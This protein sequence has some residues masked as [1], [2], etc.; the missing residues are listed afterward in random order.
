MQNKN[1]SETAAAF[2]RGGFYFIG[3]VVFIAFTIFYILTCLT[4]PLPLF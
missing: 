2:M 3:L 1:K 4:T